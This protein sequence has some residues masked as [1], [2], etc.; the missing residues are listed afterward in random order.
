VRSNPPVGCETILV[1]DDEDMV[2]RATRIMLT[3]GGYSVLESCNG[4]E[5]LALLASRGESIDLIVLDRSMPGRPGEE[6]LDGLRRLVPDLPVVL[7]SG[8]PFSAESV[9]RANAALLKPISTDVLL[10]T[11]RSLLDR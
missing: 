8:Q 5:A 6:V 4:D 10:G 3:R 9:A 1:V 2:R 7:L 11:I